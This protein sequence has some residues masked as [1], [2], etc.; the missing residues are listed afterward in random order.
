MSFRSLARASI[1][2]SLRPFGLRIGRHR[3]SGP[4]Y[5][6]YLRRALSGVDRPIVLDIGANTG[7]SALQFFQVCPKAEV[8]SFE[9]SPEAF[10]EMIAKVHGPGFHAH[11]LAIGE[12]DGVVAFHQFAQ[13]QTASCLGPAH[14]VAEYAPYLVER[15]GSVEVPV[16]RL[17]TIL[18]TLGIHGVIDYMKIDVQGYEDRVL[19]GGANALRRTRY[20][21]VEANFSPVYEGSCLVDTLCHLLYEQGF[22]LRGTVGYLLGDNIDELLS[23]DFLF[24]RIASADR[25]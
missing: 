18:P 17:D 4:G 23:A 25:R 2:S 5:E 11:N 24:E 8:H 21:M 16:R 13:S 6:Q 3:P 1:N 12:C 20:V 22:R 15:T 10:G 7:Q 19:R 14:G 9:P